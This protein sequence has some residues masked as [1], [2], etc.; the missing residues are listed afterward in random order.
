[1]GEECV[2]KFDNKNNVVQRSIVKTVAT[3]PNHNKRDAENGKRK[4][5]QQTSSSWLSI[6][7]G[8]Q[9]RNAH[10]FFGQIARE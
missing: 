7:M 6:V 10:F 3:R 8:K 1:M 4:L 2:N 9:E 5:F